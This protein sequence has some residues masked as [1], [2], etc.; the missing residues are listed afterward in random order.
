[1][2][3]SYITGSYIRAAAVFGMKLEPVITRPNTI[4][5]A[6]RA[7]QKWICIINHTLVHH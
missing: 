3:E 2:R 4:A 7:G 5:K 6:Q 1:M